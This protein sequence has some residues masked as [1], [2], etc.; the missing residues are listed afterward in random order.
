MI[1]GRARLLPWRTFTNAVE[2]AGKLIG[3]LKK[4]N[5][6]EG[7]HPRVHETMNQRSYALFCT[8]ARRRSKSGCKAS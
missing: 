4:G 1:V 8:I 2:A 7:V 5:A 6:R 3:Q